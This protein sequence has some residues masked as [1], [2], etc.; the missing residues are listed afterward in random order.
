MYITGADQEKK[1]SRGSELPTLNF[2]KQKKI[3]CKSIRVKQVIL[4]D[5]LAAHYVFFNILS[6]LWK[7][8]R[9]GGVWGPPLEKCEKN[10]FVF[11]QKTPFDT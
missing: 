4:C 1:I 11:A 6:E 7:V 9:G 2:N 10:W 5:C 3:R 8:W